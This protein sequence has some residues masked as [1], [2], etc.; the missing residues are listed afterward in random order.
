MVFWLQVA[1]S[2]STAQRHFRL[3]RDA[4]L[5]VL[6]WRELHLLDTGSVAV[7]ATVP[8]VQTVQRVS[9]A[10]RAPG[11]ISLFST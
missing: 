9:A 5:V 11:S 10:T 1:H 6:R 3:D 8:M 2:I 4:H 7:D